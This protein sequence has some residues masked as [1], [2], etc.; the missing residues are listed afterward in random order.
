MRR[1]QEGEQKMS[2]GKK[3][4][5]DAREGK[6]C[7]ETTVA[8]LTALHSFLLTSIMRVETLLYLGHE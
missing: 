8:S 1:K 3:W 6:S 2:M 4:L 7:G 5:V